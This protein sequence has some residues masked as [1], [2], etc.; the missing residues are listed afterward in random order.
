LG[1][2][3]NKEKEIMM[4][5]NKFIMPAPFTPIRGMPALGAPCTSNRSAMETSVGFI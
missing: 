4:R 1:E 3:E 5:N 2:L